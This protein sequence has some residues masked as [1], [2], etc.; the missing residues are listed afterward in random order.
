MKP[1]N[2]QNK[3]IILYNN[4]NTFILTGQQLSLLEEIDTTVVHVYTRF[5]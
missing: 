1:A 2:D 4:N 3:C 5:Q